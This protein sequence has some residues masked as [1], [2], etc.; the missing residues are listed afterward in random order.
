MT[1]EHW[2][3]AY[4][5]ATEHS[6]DQTG[7]G[8]DLALLDEA[9]LHVDDSVIDVGGGDGAFSEALLRRGHQDL[10]VLDIASSALDAGRARLG[11]AQS[12]VQ[13]ISTDVRAWVP[14]RTW[15]IWHDRAAF[16]FLTTEDDRK[17]YRRALA[18]ATEAGSLVCVGTFAENGPTH[19]SGLPVARYSPEGLAEALRGGELDLDLLATGHEAHR[20][21]HGATQEFAWVVLRLA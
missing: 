12:R 2:Q 6:W 20:T 9:G 10:T 15:R 5:N 14:D 19:C 18:S 13:W 11:E 16:H 7:A 17:G 3:A 8:A 21:P 1:T 4:E